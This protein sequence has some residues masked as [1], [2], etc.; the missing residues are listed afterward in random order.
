MYQWRPYQSEDDVQKMRDLLI[1]GRAANNGTYYFHSGDLDWG[2]YR[3]PNEQKRRDGI[4]LWDGDAHLLG[5]VYAPP[6]D[7][8]LDV[9]IHPSIHC[10]AQAKAMFDQAIDWSVEQAKRHQQERLEMDWVADTDEW[11]RGQLAQYGFAS[12]N[13]DAVHFTRDLAHLP[14]SPL[15]AGYHIAS[16]TSADVGVQRAQATY[17]AFNNTAPWAEYLDRYQRFFTSPAHIGERDLVV[18]SPDGFGVSACCIWFDMTNRVGLFEPVGTHPDFQRKGLGK[19][20]MS[21]ALRRMKAAGLTSAIVSAND[22]NT[23][24]ITLYQSMGFAIDMRLSLFEK[25]LVG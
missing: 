5:W 20:L 17:R 24:G 23:N 8:T 16:V 19:A 6:Q 22:T 15:P 2:L 9:Y 7:G 11:L 10:T 21:E 13:R 1:A 12:A 3:P 14:D 25:R 4:R 18:V